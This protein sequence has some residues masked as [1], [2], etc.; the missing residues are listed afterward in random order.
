MGTQPSQLYMTA[1]NPASTTVR[2]GSMWLAADCCT[3]FS[4]TVKTTGTLTGAFKFYSSNDPRA[5]QDATAADQAAAVWDE[6]TTEIASQITN[7]SASAV[8]FRV[9]VSDFRGGFLHMD[10]VG[11][12]AGAGTISSWYS[13]LGA[14]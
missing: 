3:G 5:R 7:P 1:T 6:F 13:G 8:Q 9:M 2:G 11:G 14:G 10:Y 4:M 12:G